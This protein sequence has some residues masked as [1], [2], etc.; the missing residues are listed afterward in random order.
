MGRQA[1]IKLRKISNRMIA[2]EAMA[3]IERITSDAVLKDISNAAAAARPTTP[4]PTPTRS[5][6]RTTT[7]A[8]SPNMHHNMHMPYQQQ[9]EYLQ[10]IE[11]YPQSTTMSYQEMQNVPV[12]F[13]KM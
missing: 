10:Q 6:A 4:L 1:A 9:Y 7:A 8:A 13:N 5:K 3:Q 11:Q 12:D 2:M